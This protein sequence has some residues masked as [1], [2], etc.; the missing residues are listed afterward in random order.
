MILP[1]T[2]SILNT[3]FRGRDR[4]IA[5]GIWGATIGGMA[6]VGPLLGGWLTTYL[7]WRWAFFINIPVAIIAIFGTLRYIGESKD[8][9]AKAGPRPD[10]LPAHHRR[11][12][13]V[14][15]RP[16]RGPHATAG[17][18]PSKPFAI[19]GWTWPLETVSIIPFAL[20]GGLV[21]LALF[22]VGRGPPVPGGQVLPVRRRPVAVPGVPLRQPGR[23]DRLARR[24]RP[25]VRAAA[26]PPGR[27]S[28][29]PRSRPGSC[30]CRWRSARSSRP[31]WPHGSPT[32][33][34]RAARSP[35]ACASR[36]SASSRT[37]AAHLDRPSRAS[38]SRCRCSSTASASA[39]RR[40][41]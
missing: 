21:A 33:T 38:S 36:R 28:A 40:R 10:R 35:W 18:R 7:S 34:A 15:L 1:S 24:V 26:V 9:H 4:A 6:A 5:F 13:R 31:R 23:H 32:G 20:V 8:E 41:S 19:L 30:S 17:G 27:P 16:H 22:L 25:P 2:Q 12:R 3:N 11:P 37:L 39:S 29:T 14:R